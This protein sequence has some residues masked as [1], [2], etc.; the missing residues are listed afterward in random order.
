[1]YVL[2]ISERTERGTACVRVKS[3]ERLMYRRELENLRER[4]P[5]VTFQTRV[6]RDDDTPVSELVAELDVSVADFNEQQI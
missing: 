4:Y 2:V 3:L 6:L 5:H 1:M